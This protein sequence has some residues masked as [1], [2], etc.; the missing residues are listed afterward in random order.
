MKV[1]IIGTQSTYTAEPLY[2]FQCVDRKHVIH[3]G[4]NSLI[5]S[6]VVSDYL[7]GV[8]RKVYTLAPDEEVVYSE[9]V[10]DF[11]KGIKMDIPKQAEV[12]NIDSGELK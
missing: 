10:K 12:I 1:R 11:V 8:P 9:L 3:Y 2:E 5:N 7:T 6:V 4:H